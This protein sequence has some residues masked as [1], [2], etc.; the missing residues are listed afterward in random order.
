MKKPLQNLFL[1][2]LVGIGLPVA[3]QPII[4][5]SGY[6]P[7]IGSTVSNVTNGGGFSQG[8]AGANQ[9]W[10]L[11]TIGNTGNSTTSFVSVGSVPTG[12]LFPSAS[13]AATSS[14]STVFYKFTANEFQNVGMSI[15]TINFI[16]S[17]PEVY[18]RFPMTMGSTYTDHFKC[19]FTSGSTFIREGNTT[20]TAD[21]YGTVMTPNGTYNNVL[22]VHIQQEYTDST[23]GFVIP[24]L[25]HIYWW[26]KEGVKSPLAY[27]NTIESNGTITNNGGY[28]TGNVGIF[29]QSEVFNSIELYPVPATNELNVALNSD[30]YQK[31]QFKITNS[32]GQAVIEQKNYAIQA[33][34]NLYNIDIAQLLEGVYFLQII[35]DNGSVETKKFTVN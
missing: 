14:G 20:V 13:I 7:S 4:T 3:A 26:I 29:D 31:S 19:S 34:N 23:D 35:L 1:V 18:L 12:A 24:Y 22:R 30:K 32:L 21:G 9:T 27:V 17:D 6:T 28:L 16:Y 15:S 33:G 5:I 11:S 10:D 8:A 25:V 2:C